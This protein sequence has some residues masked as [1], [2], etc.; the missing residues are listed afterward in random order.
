MMQG[1]NFAS[2][3]ARLPDPVL[4]RAQQELLVR[5]GDGISAAE[6]PF[7]GP[8]FRATL[9]HARQRLAELLALP[10]NYRILFLAGG[11]M[12]Q[13]S[14]VPLNLL[15]DS[16]R[17][18]YADS[19][20]WSRRA[21]TEAARFADITL[22]AQFTGS[23]PLA[24]PPLEGWQLPPDSA[25]CHITPNE[26]V[27]GVAYPAL[28]ECGGV[29]LVADATSCLLT[30]PL[31]VSRFGLIYAAAQKNIGIAGMT[32]VIVRED[33]LQRPAPLAPTPFSYRIQAEQHSCVNTPPTVAIALAGMVFDWIADHGGL[34]AM[35]ERNR[36]KAAQLYAAIDGS[37]GFYHAPVASGH[38]STSNVR[39]HLANDA[40]TEP[41]IAA[42]EQ[43]GLHNLRG[44]S[45]IGG[46]R[47]SLYNAMPEAGVAAL[48]ACMADFARRYG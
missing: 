39:F 36:R 24:A 22:A 35:G 25:Y 40:L 29:P 43:R 20:Y 27:D 23:A 10:D 44:H 19:G 4:A 11:A 30:A 8:V 15:G 42:A 9:A 1:Y 48:T 17:A 6:R 38:R 18:A 34:V 45:Q 14:M 32:L 5:G 7:T 13:F 37:G 12:H 2:G 41:F 3:P 31:D 16:R 47:A 26:T 21:M 33:L 46:L 28:P